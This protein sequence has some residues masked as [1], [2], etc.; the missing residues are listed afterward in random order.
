MD[1]LYRPLFD[2]VNAEG[3]RTYARFNLALISSP[4]GLKFAIDS[5]QL[6]PISDHVLDLLHQANP[7]LPWPLIR[8]RQR[9]IAL[10][11]LSSLFSRRPPYALPE[12]DEALIEDA[13]DMAT[14]A[15]TA[16]LAPAVAQM[17]GKLDWSQGV[18]R[19]PTATASA[20]P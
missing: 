14:A 11:V 7:G 2:H 5:F 13:L 1:I 16:P 10:M 15:I 4:S 20:K 8:E 12:H 18:V 9:L 6:M 17:M 3:E 19:G